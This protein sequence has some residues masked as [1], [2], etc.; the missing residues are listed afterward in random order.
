VVVSCEL[1]R[2]TIIRL[3][4]QDPRER[5]GEGGEPREHVRGRGSGK[6]QAIRGGVNRSM[7]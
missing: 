6:H 1:V 5:R 3:V 7:M 2:L 4:L